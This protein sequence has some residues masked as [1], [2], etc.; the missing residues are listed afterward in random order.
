MR[1]WWNRF[2]SMFGSMFVGE[3]RRKP[4]QQMRQFTH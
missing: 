3:I 2:G 1:L 4:V